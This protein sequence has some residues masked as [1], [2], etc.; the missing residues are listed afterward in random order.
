MDGG[1]LINTILKVIKKVNIGAY[2]C[3]LT[4]V[5]SQTL[6]LHSM[7]SAGLYFFPVLSI[8]LDIILETLNQNLSQV[9]FK[10]IVTMLKEG[11]MLK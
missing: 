7:L 5:T 8:N 3:K 6:V 2:C 11:V 4:T 9:Y 10:L 1:K